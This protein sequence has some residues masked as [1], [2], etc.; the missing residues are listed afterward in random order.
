MTDKMTPQAALDRLETLYNQSVAN[1][2][3]AVKRF[4][5]TGERANPEARAAGL[6]AYPRLTV[7][8]FGDRPQD[9]ETRA[10]ARLS[11]TGVYTTTVTRPDLYRDYLLEQLSLLVAEYGATLTVEPSDQEI[12][13]PYVLDG[14]GVA[15]DSTMTASIARWFPTTDLAHIGDEI[16]DGLFAPGE[17]FPWPS[18]TVCAPTSRWPACVTTP[19]LRS[20]TCSPMSCSPTITAMSTSSCAGPAPSW[21]TRPASIRP[22]R[23]PAA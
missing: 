22:C 21:P 11:R 18:S 8:W 19:A 4:L 3:A 7:S 1:L 2:R 14:S 13:F 12:P 5:E 6:F 17:D 10:F 15:L 20:R 9:L 23:A 16:S